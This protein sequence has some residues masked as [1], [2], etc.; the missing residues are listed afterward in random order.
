MS[1]KKS[2]R[3]L[4]N[5][6]YIFF[7]EFLKN[8]LKIGSIFPSS[9]FLEKRILEETRIASSKTI[10]ELGSGTGSMTRSVLNAMAQHAKLLSIEINPHFY[11]L[12]S[13]IKDDRL[14]AH[15]GNACEL[16]KIISRY[17]LDS[18]E[19]VI[20]GIPFST[21]SYN[22]GSQIL[23]AVSTILAPNGRLVAYQVSNRVASLC[24]P[25]LGPGQSVVEFLNIP[26]VRVYQWRKRD[27]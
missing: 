10:V 22:A 1:K 12:V 9:C 11:N 5:G 19:I 14:I 18:P 7:K 8:P 24:R 17:E 27:V 25:F 16:K 26:P 20:S 2:I 15:M 13:S 6:R 4:M 23:E 3:F 21:M